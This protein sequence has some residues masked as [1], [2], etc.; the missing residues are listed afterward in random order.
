MMEELPT[1]PPKKGSILKEVEKLR[2]PLNFKTDL[3]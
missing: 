1:K 2:P 3:K